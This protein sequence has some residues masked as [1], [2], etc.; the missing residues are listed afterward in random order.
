MKKE[1]LSRT[2]KPI[3][4][5]NTLPLTNTITLLVDGSYLIKKSFLGADILNNSQG[6]HIGALYSFIMTIRKIIKE[7][8]AN[9]CVVF[10]DGNNSGKYRYTLYEDYKANRTSKDWYKKISLSEKEVLN[11]EI[12]QKSLLSQKVKIQNYLENLYIRQIE[13]EYI[14]S[15]DLIA[16]YC[17][18]YHKEE[19]IHIYTNDRDMCQL[20]EY[21]N[22]SIYLANQKKLFNKDNYFLLFK[23]SYKN[24]KLIKTI[25]GDSSDNI[26]GIKG[27]GETVLL[28]HF[29]ELNDNT[30]YDFYYVINKAK[31]INE[32]RIKNKQKPLAFLDN[33]VDGIF[34]GDL[35]VKSAINQFKIY[36]EI[37]DLLNPILNHEAIHELKVISEYPLDIENRTSKHLLEMMNQDS[38]FENYKGSLSS[39]TEPFHPLILKEKQLYKENNN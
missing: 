18:N 4:K 21:D 25:C 23:H 8:N 32:E 3:P 16:Q 39:F 30:T 33:I 1:V 35:K 37:I 19:K 29:P 9:K 5:L 20:I 6:T 14:E 26:K 34:S 31:E 36:D 38:F 10:F 13:C 24:L 17:K 12:K 15:D 2:V 7:T 11:E 28:K 22:V 27:C